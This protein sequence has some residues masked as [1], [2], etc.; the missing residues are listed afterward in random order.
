MREIAYLGG[1]SLY[2]VELPSGA[3]LRSACRIRRGSL[4]PPSPAASASICPGRP[5]RP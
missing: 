5:N 2:R 3:I 1:L 4:D